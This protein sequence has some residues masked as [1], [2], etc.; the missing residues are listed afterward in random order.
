LYVANRQT[1]DGLSLQ[2]ATPDGGTLQ[3]ALYSNTAGSQPGTLLALSAALP[4]NGAGSLALPIAAPG[5]VIL[6]PGTVWLAFQVSGGAG[7]Y[8]LKASALHTCD[9]QYYNDPGP[10]PAGGTESFPAAVGALAQNEGNG[11]GEPAVD[12][13]ACAVAP[14]PYGTPGCSVA[15]FYDT[16]GSGIFSDD[17]I[18]FMPLYV[19]SRQT[20]DA[21][22]LQVAV[23][24]GSTLQC[25]LYSNDG[26]SQ[27]GTL[28]ALS[29]AVPAPGAGAYTLALAA[30]GGL[31][32]APGTV[33]LAFQATGGSGSYTLSASAEQTCDYRIYADP[34]PPPAGL[35]ELFPTTAGSSAQDEGDGFG[36]LAVD[37]NACPVTPSPTVSPSMSPTPTQ[38]L[39]AT[40]TPGSPTST[41]TVTPLL[42]D[43]SET[44]CGGICSLT[45]SDPQNCG[46][47][48]VVCPQGY[49]CSGGG[50]VLSCQ[51]GETACSGACVNL[52]NSLQNCG[53]CGTTCPPGYVCS[54]GGCVLSCETGETNCSNTCVLLKTNN[55]NCGACGV[56]CPAGQVCV[57][58]AC[59]CPASE[60]NACGSGAAAF[61]TNIQSDPQNCGACGRV[62]APGQVC[63]GGGCVVSCVS[64]ETGCPSS[65]PVGCYNL[66]DDSQNCGACGMVCPAGQSCNGSSCACPADEPNACGSGVNAICTSFQ[67]DL[68]NCGACGAICP[69][70]QI[71]NG[72]HCVPSCGAPLSVCGGVCVNIANDPSNCGGCG[73]QCAAGYAC[74]GSGCVKLAPTPTP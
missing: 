2:V 19:A 40:N 52:S 64:G 59:G 62:C 29:G 50:C 24:D 5:S 31:T 17:D 45:S 22:S 61:C 6:G 51:S 25:A 26:S 1:V 69:A 35:A 71:C 37:L 15:G 9:Y 66:T 72:G 67:T 68:H 4:M 46:S 54:G 11:F 14:S 73:V 43:P 7:T 8:S 30:P 57:N 42:C 65:S 21:I 36:A 44:N 10:P 27:P 16:D 3:C 20:V 74:S 49:T 18:Y 63:N 23:S 58:G 56:V 28:L 12:L 13:N 53:A 41:T 55:Q 34:S 70:G 32:L 38:T 47:C 33:W 48:G 60:P 39:S